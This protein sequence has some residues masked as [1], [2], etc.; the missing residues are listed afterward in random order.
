MD[1]AIAD[2]D[3]S[4]CPHNLILY[5]FLHVSAH[6]VAPALW[7]S[8]VERLPVRHC[9]VLVWRGRTEQVSRR[10]PLGRIDCCL[11]D[12]SGTRDLDACTVFRRCKGCHRR[13]VPISRQSACTYC[14]KRNRSSLYISWK[15]TIINFM[16][17]ALVLF[18]LMA[19]CFIFIKCCLSICPWTWTKLVPKDCCKY[20]CNLNKH[21][22][23]IRVIKTFRDVCLGYKISW[24]FFS[25]Q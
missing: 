16:R 10:G 12:G 11:S 22:V 18:L 20:I 9:R 2:S 21:C 14:L 5:A 3:T 4:V 7:L 25:L 6:Q 1:R 23:N 17:Y 13:D 8:A 15:R 19:R 24:W